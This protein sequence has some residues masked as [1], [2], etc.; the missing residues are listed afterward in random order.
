MQKKGLV[1]FWPILVI[2]GKYILV[3]KHICNLWTGCPC[4]NSTFVS[5]KQFF[6]HSNFLLF[7]FFIVKPR[8]VAEWFLFTTLLSIT[9]SFLA[10]ISIIQLQIE[11]PMKKERCGR[12][13]NNLWFKV[14]F[15]F[16]PSSKI[17]HFIFS[18][19]EPCAVTQN[20][21]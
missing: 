12:L 4:F 7:L 5:M 1:A 6:H 13:L 15:L 10:S 17:F 19:V 16:C 11:I 14:V 3:Y 21:K 20:H 8:V 2:F 9:V 18:F